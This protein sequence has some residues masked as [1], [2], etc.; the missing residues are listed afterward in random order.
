MVLVVK[1]LPANAQLPET[2]VLSL[3]QE[4]PLQE[5]MATRSYILACMDRGAWWLQSI[6]S[7]R[8]W[9]DWSDWALCLNLKRDYMFSEYFFPS[10]F[11]LLKIH[12]KYF[13][14][15]AS[16]SEKLTKTKSNK[17]LKT[18][19]N[20]YLTAEGPSSEKQFFHSPNQSPVSLSNTWS[21]LLPRSATHT[22]KRR[23][24]VTGECPHHNEKEGKRRGGENDFIFSSFISTPIEDLEDPKEEH[25][26]APFSDT[27]FNCRRLNTL[28][29]AYNRWESHTWPWPKA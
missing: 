16:S 3:G 22:C 29:S 27:K 28:E 24:T 26:K 13:K 25:V 5:G 1:N 19:R 23:K 18:K 15:S 17:H 6:G 21:L 2:R 10:P 7:Q 4:D 9:H 12:N 20:D 8:V 11:S 14:L